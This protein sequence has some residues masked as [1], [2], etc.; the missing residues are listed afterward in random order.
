[1]KAYRF[2]FAITK[3][4]RFDDHFIMY[5][6]RIILKIIKKFFALMKL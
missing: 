3:R 5:K 1:M 6:S 2:F 4:I